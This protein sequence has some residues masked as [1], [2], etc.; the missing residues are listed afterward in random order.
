MPTEEELRE[1]AIKAI[2]KKRDFWNHVIAYCIVN[3]F[4]VVIWYWN[5]A[6]LLLAGLGARRLGH[7]ARLQRVGR[8]RT[9]QPAHQRGRDPAGDR[10]AAARL[11]RGS[12][13]PPAVTAGDA[14]PAGRHFPIVLPSER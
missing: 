9:R 6:G 10:P 8:L 1:H 12:T 7:R 14:P 3:I 13:A 11:S 4:L 5:G 2:K